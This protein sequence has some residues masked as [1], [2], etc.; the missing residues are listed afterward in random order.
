MDAHLR[1]LGIEP[2][3]CWKYQYSDL[4]TDLLREVVNGQGVVADPN[5]VVY[6][7]GSLIDSFL[8]ACRRN[9]TDEEP[10]Q[11]ERYGIIWRHR[12]LAKA[13][14][15]GFTSKEACPMD[16]NQIVDVAEMYMKQ[17][18][19][20]PKLESLLV[21]ALI[22]KEVYYF[23]EDLKQ[24]PSKYLI[25][26]LFRFLLISNEIEAY[27]KAKG[28]FDKLSIV[29][30]KGGIKIFL[31]KFSLFYLAPV[32]I[33]LLAAAVGVPAI[34]VIAIMFVSVLAAYQLLSWVWRKLRSLFREPDKDPLTKAFELH[35]QMI[36]AYSE[37]RGGPS[38]S[39]QRVREMLV[40]AA[41]Q[42]AMWEPVVFSILD[43]AI[44]RSKGNWG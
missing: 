37:L 9:D 32:V 35:A 28:N 10:G 43:A 23:G 41:D 36:R 19:R 31:L 25:N 27:D 7:A 13:F 2:K 44:A 21:D 1:R 33:A 39:P 30:L 5:D 20:S 14:R 16:K 34:S 11:P 42:G 8:W 22:A 17:N 15:E 40:S 29:W 12:D 24:T 6:R 26:F 18:L 4:L 3:E 38:S